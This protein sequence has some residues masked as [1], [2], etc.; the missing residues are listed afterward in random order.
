MIEDKHNHQR[1]LENEKERSEMATQ[2]M[3]QREKGILLVQAE[4]RWI[5]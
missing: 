2:I 3:T 5:W 4:N 1:S